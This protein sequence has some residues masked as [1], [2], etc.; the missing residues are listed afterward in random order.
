VTRLVRVARLAAL[1][2]AGAFAAVLAV[3]RSGALE[4]RP[5]RLA[6]LA[7][8]VLVAAL[9][10]IALAAV[11]L[12][13]RSGSPAALAAEAVLFLGLAL[14]SGAGLANWALGIQGVA[15]LTEG[16]AIP[17]DR[18]AHLQELSAG[19]LARL[20]DVG[21]ALRLAKVELKPAEGGAFVPESVV[22]VVQGDRV[23]SLRLTPARGASVGE[24]LLLQGAF[25][26]APR[27]VVQ[28][29]GATVLDRT[30]PFTTRREGPAGVAFEADLE[31]ASHGLHVVAAVDL[32]DVDERMKGHP[33]ISVEVRRGGEV[34]GQG[35]LIPGHG[36]TMRDGWHIGYGG[37]RMWSEIDLRR[38]SYRLP[39]LLGAA[40]AAA[41]AVAW[42]LAGRRR[43]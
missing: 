7:G 23:L 34:L 5:A 33:A 4:P 40:L 32:D 36:A 15:V 41:G 21:G 39:V 35:R 9:A 18:G 3:T 29:D 43:R 37:M 28:K 17:L 2:L 22:E 10:S 20:S 42:P 6:A 16:D 14:V 1:L 26:F 25:G 27:I 30:V 11:R 8:G 31:V 13:R 19:P 24:L 38:R 12:V